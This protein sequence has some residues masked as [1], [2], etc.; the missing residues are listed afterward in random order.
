ML[1]F[2]GYIQILEIIVQKKVQASF[3]RGEKKEMHTG[4]NK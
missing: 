2:Y 4:V 3:K 1:N